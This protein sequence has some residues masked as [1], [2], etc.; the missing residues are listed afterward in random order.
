MALDLSGLT[1]DQQIAAAAA[2][3]GVPE[4]VVRG[5]WRVESGNGTAQ[6][7]AQGII[8]SEAGARG[9][10]Q[11]MP[12]TQAVIEARTGKKYDVRNFQDSLEMYAHIMRENMQLAKGDVTT[13][14]RIYHGGTDR[15]NWGPK[16]AAYAPAVLGGAA[17]AVSPQ[18]AAQQGSIN[19]AWAGAGNMTTHTWSGASIPAA[20]RGDAIE[21]GGGGLGRATK[22]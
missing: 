17:P 15:A 1:Q 4:S 10:F 6:R 19:A 12:Q 5:Q 22:E 13:A 20:W 14:L 16:N 21:G 7:D 2:Y 8:T 18:G 11:I 3:A 9:D